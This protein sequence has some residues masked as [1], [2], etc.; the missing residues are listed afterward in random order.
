[1]K[2]KK[3]RFFKNLYMGNNSM[4]SINL[5]ESLIVDMDNLMYLMGRLFIGVS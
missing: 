1:M 2:H 5:I 3:Q 4:K